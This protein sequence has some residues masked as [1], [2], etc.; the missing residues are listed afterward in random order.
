MTDQNNNRPETVR[1]DN[2]KASIWR[3]E[4]ERG[5]FYNTQF[6]RV[7]KDQQGNY[8]ETD[9]FSKDDVLKLSE[10]ARSAYTRINELQ[11]RDRQQRQQHDPQ[12]REAFREKRQAQRANE[13]QR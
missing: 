4:G 13:P 11:Q 2:L 6:S 12:A 9:S 7:Y 8:H 5:A 3:N 1:L 10:L